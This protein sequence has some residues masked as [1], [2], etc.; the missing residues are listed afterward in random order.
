LT[1]FF[2][3]E[4]ILRLNPIPSSTLLQTISGDLPFLTSLINSSQTSGCVPSDFKMARV[5][6]L[7]KKPTL[8]VSDVKNYKPVSLSFLSKTL[9][10]AVS[11]FR[12]QNNLLD[13]NQLVFKRVHSTMTALFCITEALCAAKVESFSSLLILLDPSTAFD[14]VNL[15]ALLSTLSGLCTLLDCILP[16]RPLHTRCRGEDLSTPHILARGVT[17]GSVLG[18]KSLISIISYHCMWMTL[19][20]FS[21]SPF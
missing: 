11:C 14:T 8:C 5:A 7:L 15:Q 18:T 19:N 10:S 6:P 16:G 17:Q 1:F 4:E 21:P 2:S 13:P 20:Y 12:P 9:E 3:P